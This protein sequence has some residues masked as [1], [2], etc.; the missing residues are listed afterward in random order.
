M[1]RTRSVFPAVICDLSPAHDG[2]RDPDD[3]IGKDCYDCTRKAMREVRK[4]DP[5][6]GVESA[7]RTVKDRRR[8]V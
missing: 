6:T 4:V 3:L 7:P 2:R 5:D 1:A 8:S